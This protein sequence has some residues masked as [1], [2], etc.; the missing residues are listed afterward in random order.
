MLN[1]G[2][3]VSD[4]VDFVCEVVG[5]VAEFGTSWV[6]GAVTLDVIVGDT[7][8]ATLVGLSGLT[9]ETGLAI[10]VGFVT[11]FVQVFCDVIHVPL[12]IGCA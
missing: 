3:G 10:L 4:A 9:G 7:G 11:D 2:V 1:F 12:Q 5:V 8:V 6:V